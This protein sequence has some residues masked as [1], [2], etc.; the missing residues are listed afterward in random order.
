MVKG[1]PRAPNDPSCKLGTQKW[2]A[3]EP[4]PLG[5]KFSPKVILTPRGHLVMSESILC[6]HN[7]EIGGDRHL[8]GE[9]Q[10]CCV[11]SYPSRAAPSA[12]STPPKFNS[13][14]VEKPCPRMSEGGKKLTRSMHREM[15]REGGARERE[16]I[17]GPGGP[18]SG[19]VFGVPG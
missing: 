5:Q 13:A 16:G 9:D 4:C 14:E 1:T 6:C 18:G 2:G 10:G 15:V 19:M 3:L 12:E 8:V 17:R 7:L 11:T